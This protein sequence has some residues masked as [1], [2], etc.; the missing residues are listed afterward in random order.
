MAWLCSES[1]TELKQKDENIYHVLYSFIIHICELQ[2]LGQ[3]FCST[4]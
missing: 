1:N 2:I 3:S 4:T